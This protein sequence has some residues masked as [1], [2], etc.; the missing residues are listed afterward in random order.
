[1]NNARAYLQ[2][3][4]KVDYRDCLIAYYTYSLVGSPIKYNINVNIHMHLPSRQLKKTLAIDEVFNSNREAIDYGIIKGKQYIDKKHE[5]EVT[6]LKL[7]AEDPI[8]KR[9]NLDK[10]KPKNNSFPKERQ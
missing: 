1:M 4:G 2:T 9:D 8:L 10:H 5:A 6:F 3:E 7:E